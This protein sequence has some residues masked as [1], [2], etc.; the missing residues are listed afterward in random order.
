MRIFVLIF[1]ASLFSGCASSEH[2]PLLFGQAQTLGISVGAAAQGQ[3]PE[4]TV[5]YKDVNIAH[6]PTVVLAE[7]GSGALIQG[8]TGGKD[9]DAYSTFGQFEASTN[10]AETSLG[11]FFA[12]GIAA[13]Y[14][15][16]G[17]ACEAARG[18]EAKCTQ[19]PAF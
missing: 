4:L 6:I 1:L 2:A 7:D 19:R 8:E 9:K 3:A 15:A 17:F 18:T 14:L 5:G 12:T 16:E 13:R 11:K 10:A